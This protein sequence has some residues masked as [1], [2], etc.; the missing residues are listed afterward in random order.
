[1]ITV[2]TPHQGIVQVYRPIEAGEFDKDNSFLWLA[3][4]ALLSLYRQNPLE[5]KK[6]IIRKNFPALYDLFPIFTFLKNGLQQDIQIDTLLFKN[7]LLNVYKNTVQNIF[8]KL[9]SIFGEKGQETPAGFVVNEPTLVDKL[10]GNYPDGRPYRQFSGLGDYLVLSK[11]ANLDSDSQKIPFDHTEIITEKDGI[12]KVLD[13]LGLSYQENQI[14][15]G[16]KTILSPSLI[17]FIKSPV[18]VE[19]EY[20]GTSYNEQDGLIF[21]PKAAF[22][23]YII[24][25]KGKEKGPY[26]IIIGQIGIEKDTWSRIEGKITAP[27]PLSQEDRYILSFDP[28]NPR[29][30]SINLND[31]YLLFDMLITELESINETF[32]NS[33]LK[34]AIKNLSLAKENYNKKDFV[35]MKKHLHM[36]QWTIIKAWREIKDDKKNKLLTHMANLE[37][38]FEKSLKNQAESSKN[39]L[40]KRLYLQK[41]IILTTQENLLKLKKQGAD[42]TVKASILSLFMDK[43][44]KVEEAL[45][46]GN[47]NY[48]E[49][50]LQ[51]NSYLK[52][53]LED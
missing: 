51:T 17:F 3:G 25:V 29:E 18:A 47:M 14:V 20:K 31:V 48:A 10:F 36:S 52:K 42:I 16:E 2:A 8:S 7:E 43:V 45:T 35:T 15:A 34:I 22:G 50:L 40:Q 39:I 19:V 11:S 32:Q 49:I 6:D 33:N 38:I 41:T 28:Q 37:N 53:E 30:F 26:T 1:M 13:L 23:N 9:I 5:F 21:I 46:L 24:K 44:E 12:K 27:L 4:K